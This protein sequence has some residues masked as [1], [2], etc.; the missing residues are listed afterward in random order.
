MLFLLVDLCGSTYKILQ[1]TQET[2][3]R[4]DETSWFEGNDDAA[5]DGQ[6]DGVAI[7]LTDN[8]MRILSL[9]EMR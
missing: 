5:K 8:S 7:P 1:I 2:E 6:S 3:R 4:Q 9:V